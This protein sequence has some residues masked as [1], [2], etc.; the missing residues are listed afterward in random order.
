M[1]PTAY[2]ATTSDSTEFWKPSTARPSSHRS[3]SSPA[4]NRSTDEVASWFQ[5]NGYETIGHNRW[6]KPETGTEIA[7]AH[8]GNLIKTADGELI[9]IDLQVLAEGEPFH[10]SNIQHSTFNIPALLEVRGEIFMPNEAFAAMNDERDE[11]GLPTFA[12][13]RNATA[14]TL[15]QLDP[16]IVATRPLAFLAHGLGAYEGPNPSRPSTTSTACWIDS[17]SRATSP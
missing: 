3:H 9:P 1:P 2:S 4:R 11:A 6:Q 15:K 8:I 16:K 12:N 17:A 10:S 13:P 14:G 7:D 5:S